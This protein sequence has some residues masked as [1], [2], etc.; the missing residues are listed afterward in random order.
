[1]EKVCLLIG[2][3]L[4]NP[5]KQVK[6]AINS[7]NNLPNTKLINVSSFYTSLPLGNKNQPDFINA[8]T[9]INTDLTPSLLLK[10]IQIIEIN[11]G[12]I[13]TLEKWSSRSI[14]ID[15]LFFGNKIINTPKLIIPHY[16][17]YNRAFILYPLLEIIN[18][19]TQISNKINILNALNFVNKNDISIL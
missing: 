5:L 1:M 12:R 18:P 17:I 2:S 14:D 13:R 3:N 11:Q 9:E 4:L 6:L 19:L 8:I 10:Y 16:D 7:L 15:I